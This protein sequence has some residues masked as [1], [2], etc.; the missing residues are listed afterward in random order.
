MQIAIIGAGH[1]GKAIAHVLA[2]KHLAVK[3]WDINPD[4]LPEQC[5]IAGAVRGADFVFLAVPSNAVRSALSRATPFLGAQTIVVTVAKGIEA[6]TKKFMDDVLADAL[7]TRQPHAVLF[8]PM[9]AA[10][11]I[12]GQPSFAVVGSTFK[13]AREALV[14]LFSK[15]SLHVIA[16]EDARG[17]AVA[18]VLKNVYAIALGIAH[19]LGWGENQKGYLIVQAIHEMQGLVKILGGKRETALGYAG[20]GDLIA[21]GFS[22]HSRNRLVGERLVKGEPLASEGT[23]ALPI[24]AKLPGKKLLQFPVLRAM[25]EIVCHKKDTRDTFGRLLL[26]V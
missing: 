1:I 7:P 15:T 13:R 11:M 16:S 21:T 9:L 6:E 26:N 20:L 24:I 25:G 3:F 10:E 14:D 4:C 5:D 12:S 19:G 8:G 2:P 17:V 23:R 22:S 18:G